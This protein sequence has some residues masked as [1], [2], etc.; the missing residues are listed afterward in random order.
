MTWESHED[1][2]E[3]THRFLWVDNDTIRIMNSEGVE[4]L[5]D[6]R[7]NFKE[8]EFN[9][10]SAYF[11]EWCKTGHYYLNPPTIE[12]KDDIE[13]GV[14]FNTLRRLRRKYRHYKSAY[15][16]ESKRDPVALYNVLNT[17]DFNYR[18]TKERY[19]ADLSF[20]FLHWNLMEQLKNGDITAD[21]IDN[22]QIQQLIYN[23]LPGGN[24]FLH[25]LSEKGDI[26]EAI[27]QVCHPNP[28]N[29]SKYVY[30]VPFLKNFEHE[31]PM[32]KL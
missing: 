27:F 23:I 17:V 25:Y 28:E 16:L 12:T 31:S 5:I 32:D 14:V 3:T 21:Q 8:I 20:S 11:P 13:R 6:L 10:T 15:Y 24:T 4:R 19:V 29:R 9:N 1:L 22:E 18:S 30:E 26:L 2:I 7:N